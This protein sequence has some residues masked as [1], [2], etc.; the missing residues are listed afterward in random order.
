MN[1]QRTISEGPSW[2]LVRI[3]DYHISLSDT[4]DCLPGDPLVVHDPVEQLTPSRSAG[5]KF[6]ERDI[7]QRAFFSHVHLILLVS[8]W[9]GI[10]TGGSSLQDVFEVD[11]KL[12]A[13]IENDLLALVT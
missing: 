8:L 3:I 11:F 12:V 2:Y 6:P 10:R 4:M 1:P 13:E 7:E 5:A 9:L